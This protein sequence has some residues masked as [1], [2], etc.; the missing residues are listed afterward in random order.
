MLRRK[1][2]TEASTSTGPQKPAQQRHRSMRAG[3]ILHLQKQCY[4]PAQE[5][6]KSLRASN[7]LFLDFH[8]PSVTES[9][10]KI[11]QG[12]S[13]HLWI[14]ARRAQGFSS[15]QGTA[16]GA[17]Q[18]DELSG[19]R[20]CASPGALATNC[21][22]YSETAIA[23]AVAAATAAHCRSEPGRMPSRRM[24]QTCWPKAPTSISCPQVSC[25][26]VPSSRSP[27]TSPHDLDGHRDEYLG[28]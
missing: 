6:H 7:V 28:S 19:P 3:N 1:G 10:R 15:T 26:E 22:S 24:T 5:R 25:P 2:V 20:P 27:S 13:W 18:L 16:L 4:N 8:P 21:S 17:T 14:P 23:A 11:F 9:C 12:D